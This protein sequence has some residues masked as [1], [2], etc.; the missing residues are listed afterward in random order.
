M[1]SLNDVTERHTDL[2]EADLERL[3]LL[4]GDWQLLADLAFSD[5]VLW[6]PTWNGSGYVAGAQMRPTTGAT[7]FADD[8]VGT[9]LPKGR[10]AQ[11]THRRRQYQSCHS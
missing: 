1:P 10:R 2:T 11:H 5:L 8:L 7:V 9:F 3:H 6:L 4:L